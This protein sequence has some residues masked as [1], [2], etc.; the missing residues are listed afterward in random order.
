MRVK[1]VFLS[2][3][4]LMLSLLAGIA[5]APALAGE[6][7]ENTKQNAQDAPDSPACA[8]LDDPQARGLLSGGLET[9][10][11]VECGRIPEAPRQADGSLTLSPAQTDV[12][13][14][15]STTDV[16]LSTTQSETSI[17]VNP[18]T[19]TICSAYNDSQHWAVGGTG[20]SGF[21]RST[22]G[23][24]TFVDRGSFPPRWGW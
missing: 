22:D 16:G 8:L 24:V 3:L 13:V 10:L 21:S 1:S 7:L 23:G 5:A 6:Q 17:A 14:N 2:N 4:L 15:D 20:F 9:K 18:N 11:M 19:G 12:Q